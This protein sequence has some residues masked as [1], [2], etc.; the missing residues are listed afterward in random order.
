MLYS[1]TIP[2]TIAELSDNA[3]MMIGILPFLHPDHIPKELFVTAIGTHALGYSRNEA[4]LM[5][6]GRKP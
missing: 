4:D 5:E 6:I 1:L 3:R 2:L